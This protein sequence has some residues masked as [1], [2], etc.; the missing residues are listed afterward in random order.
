MSGPWRLAAHHLANMAIG[1]TATGS[2]LDRA[3]KGMSER[4]VLGLYKAGS[5]RRPG[6]VCPG[7]GAPGARGTT[8]LGSFTLGYEKRSTTLG[9]CRRITPN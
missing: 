7:Y 1:G 4:P 5:A 9:C 3:A 2:G 8:Q 6:K